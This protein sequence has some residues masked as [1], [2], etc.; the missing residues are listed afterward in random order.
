LLDLVIRA[1]LLSRN[2]HLS[3]IL[4]DEHLSNEDAQRQLADQAASG[5]LS[6]RDNSFQELLSKISGEKPLHHL[7]YQV[8]V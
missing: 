5:I 7:T 1:F 2:C 4:S 3:A 6:S 8:D